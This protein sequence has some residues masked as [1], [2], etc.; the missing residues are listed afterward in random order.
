MG[1]DKGKEM[2]LKSAKRVEIKISKNGRM[3]C[4]TNVERMSNSIRFDFHFDF[5]FILKFIVNY[6]LGSV[7]LFFFQ[8]IIYLNYTNI[9]I[10]TYSFLIIQIKYYAKTN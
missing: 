6:L 3:D 10:I 7:N 4:L 2:K 8:L 1:K 5:H 9:C